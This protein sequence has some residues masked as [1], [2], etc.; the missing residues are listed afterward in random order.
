MG[1]RQRGRLGLH[2]R[3]RHWS[4][5]RPLHPSFLVP[6]TASAGILRPPDHELKKILSD[7][8]T[9][10][11]TCHWQLGPKPLRRRS[12]SRPE[13]SIYQSALSSTVCLSAEFVRW[14]LRLL[15]RKPRSERRV[16]ITSSPRSKQAALVQLS[17]KSLSV[18]HSL[19]LSSAALHHE[20]TERRRSPF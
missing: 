15:L 5:F 18:C 2:A 8:T 17:P 16:S 1:L 7:L 20:A 4:R 11:E 9:T 14:F 12:A 13:I 19:V 3:L 6:E 10:F